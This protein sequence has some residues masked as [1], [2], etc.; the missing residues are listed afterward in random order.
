MPNT[1]AS[2][3][4]VLMPEKITELRVRRRR[5]KIAETKGKLQQ[6][7]CG[8]EEKNSNDGPSVCD[9]QWKTVIF[10]KCAQH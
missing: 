1:E 9:Y 5:K 4:D 2:T 3:K 10:R 8:E 6:R 7:K